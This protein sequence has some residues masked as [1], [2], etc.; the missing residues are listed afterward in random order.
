[1]DMPNFEPRDNFSGAPSLTALTVPEPSIS[2]WREASATMA[3]IEAA[4]ASITR[5]TLTLLPSMCLLPRPGAGP[6]PSD[7]RLR[8]RDRVRDQVAQLHPLERR[9]VGGLEHDGRRHAGLEGLLPAGGAQ[10]PLV[11]RLQA[12]EPD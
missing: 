2:G 4:G 5:S 12:G 11:A 6:M 7:G 1:M 3:K 9:R 8:P 10:A